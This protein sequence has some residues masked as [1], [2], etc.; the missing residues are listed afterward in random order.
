MDSGSR[1]SAQLHEQALV[2]WP[3][4]MAQRLDQAEFDRGSIVVLFNL[5]PQNI[6]EHLSELEL[7]QI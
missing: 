5:S 7:F 1:K 6:C 3:H 4:Q 2:E